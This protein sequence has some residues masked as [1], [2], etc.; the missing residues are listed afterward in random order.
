MTSILSR[1]LKACAG[2]TLVFLL[3]PEVVNVLVR[4]MRAVKDG[5]TV[6]E[7]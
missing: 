3:F 6:L 4:L 5:S 1:W 7:K 2:V